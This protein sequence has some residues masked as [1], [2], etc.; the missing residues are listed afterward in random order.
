MSKGSKPRP[1]DKDKFSS[2]YDTIFGKAKK[3]RI[4]KESNDDESD[5]PWAWAKD[6]LKRQE[7]LQRKKKNQ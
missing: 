5:L 6:V 3:K 1:T 2:N 7:E 4:P